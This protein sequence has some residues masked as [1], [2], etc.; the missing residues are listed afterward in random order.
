MKTPFIKPGVEWAV[1]ALCLWQSADLA[2]AWQHSPFDRLGWLALGIWLVP[3]LSAAFIQHL[4]S[5]SSAQTSWRAWTALALGLSGGLLDMH[6]LT[7]SALA[8]AFAAVAP[9]VRRRNLW[10]LLS[11]CWMPVLGWLLHGLSPVGVAVV[12]LGLASAA[13]WLSLGPIR[14]ARHAS[15]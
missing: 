10:L 3:V 1:L 5:T 6:V 8:F 9:A 4:P 12:R 2:T 15:F 11:L 14:L 13:V 7:H